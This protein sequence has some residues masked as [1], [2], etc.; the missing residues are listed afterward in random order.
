ME[1]R[2]DFPML[3]S[4][5]ELARYRGWSEAVYRD[6]LAVEQGRMAE[7]E[8]TDKYRA[9]RAILVLDVGAT[10]VRRDGCH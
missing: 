3:E 1:Q 5:A 9:T 6:L 4:P 8:F 2:P 10:D 7:A